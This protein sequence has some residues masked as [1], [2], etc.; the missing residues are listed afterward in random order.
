VLADQHGNV[1]HLGERECSIQRRNQKVV[2]EAPSPF[3]DAATRAAMGAQAVTLARAV[4]YQSAGTVEFIVDRDRNFYFLEMNTRLQV[5]HPV[6]ELV[7][8]I[9]LVEAMIRIAAG[10]KLWIAQEDVRIDGWAI[11]ARIYAEDPVRSFLPSIGRL[12]TFRPPV[13]DLA[14]PATI[15]LDSGVV[16]GS[17]VSLYYDPLLAKL[18]TY[19]DTRAAATAAMASAL[20]AFTIDGIR[21]NIP[22][23]AALMHHPRWREARLSTGFIAEEFSGGFRPEI[24]GENDRATLA[25]IAVSVELS[26]RQRRSPG[27]GALAVACSSEWALDLGRERISISVTGDASPG[28]LSLR[29]MIDGNSELEVE[30]SWRPGHRVWAGNIKGVRTIAQVRRVGHALEVGRRGAVCQARLLT[31]EAAALSALMPARTESDSSKALRCPMPGLV[32]SIAVAEGQE[33]EPGET[34]A[35]VEAMKMENVLRAERGGIVTRI[36][37]KPGDSL[38]VDAVILEFA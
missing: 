31:P 28:A 26:E 23:L 10:E 6:T 12:S 27:K 1:I 16:E 15:R 24:K 21:H 20:D 30:S 5:E 13:E 3:L 25:A 22:F 29:L 14:S 19:A 11:E 7:T 17:E 18:C 33:V 35:T 38:A 2:E 37:A 4:G 9:D 36:L 34:L 32:V 8:G